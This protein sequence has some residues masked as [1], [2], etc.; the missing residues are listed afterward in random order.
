MNSSIWIW[1]KYSDCQSLWYNNA[2]IPSANIEYQNIIKKMNKKT[3]EQQSLLFIIIVTLFI[4][5]FIQ[6]F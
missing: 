6:V 5:L 3:D 4:D 2:I 1:I